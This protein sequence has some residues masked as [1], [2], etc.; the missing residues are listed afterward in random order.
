MAIVVGRG[1]AVVSMDGQ[2]RETVDQVG[3]TPDAHSEIGPSMASEKSTG[4]Q[5][6]PSH[7]LTP[8][9]MVV[10]GKETSVNPGL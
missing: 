4:N 10:H 5:C 7:F 1:L 2:T 6:L 9:I 8:V 3:N